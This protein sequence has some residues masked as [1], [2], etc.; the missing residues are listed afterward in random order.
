MSFWFT[1][2]CAWW[3][4]V[5]ALSAIAALMLRLA[6]LRSPQSVLACWQVLLGA[7]LL[8]PVIQPWRSPAALGGSSVTMAVTTRISPRAAPPYAPAVSLLFGVLFTGTAARLMWLAIGYTRLRGCRR[9]ARPV[10]PRHEA[11]EPSRTVAGASPEVCVSCEVTAPVTFGLASPTVLLPARWLELDSARQHAILCHEFLHVRRKDWLFHV[12]EEI[13]RAVLWF[14]PAIWWVIAEIRL[15]REEVI[16]RMVVR[17]TGASRPYVEALLAFAGMNMDARLAAAP[18]FSPR[19]HLTRRIASLLEEVS[20]KKSR[21]I[22]S[23]A[24]VTVCLALA[25][26]FAIRTFPL[27]AQDPNV[28][29]VSEPGVVAPK[30]TYKVDPPYTQDAKD[31][32]IQ[33]TVIVVLEVHPDGRAHNLRIQQSLDP[34]LDQNT[35]DAISQWRFRPATKNGALVAVRATIEVNFKLF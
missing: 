31:A 3:L 10:D 35:L 30:V 23:L 27:R 26:V 15:A 13:I 28:H 9:R 17:L 14:H 11:L 12:A 29:S 24:G 6:R 7:F 25:A 5:A 19:H 16:D 21:F 34:G 8:L 22:L 2:L 18:A 33:G 4:Q 20:M 1:N 32:K